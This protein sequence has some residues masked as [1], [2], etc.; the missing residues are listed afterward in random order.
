MTRANR[1]IQ[2]GDVVEAIGCS[3]QLAYS[4]MHDC[5]HFGKAYAVG[6]L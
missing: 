3:H 1:R 5:L 6:A 2:I 4:I